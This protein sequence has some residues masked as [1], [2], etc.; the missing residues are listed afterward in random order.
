MAKGIR[1]KMRIKK[2][3]QVIVRAGRDKGKTGEVLGVFPDEGRALVANI[4]KVWRHEPP[5][6]KGPGGRNQ[7]EAKIHISNISLL[8]PK[9]NKPTKI[10]YRR[11]ENGNK[12]RFARNS[13][14]VIDNV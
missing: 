3:D 4:N 7:K 14:E 11:L 1:N 9:E 10:G 12:V 13:G 5:S 2:G 8:D 6:Q